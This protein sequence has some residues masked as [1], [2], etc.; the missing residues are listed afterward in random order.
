MCMLR[1]LKYTGG[2][3]AS[4]VTVVLSILFTKIYILINYT[5]HCRP[6]LRRTD[7]FLVNL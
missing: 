2:S 6:I 1:A 4:H 5:L 3:N 7:F